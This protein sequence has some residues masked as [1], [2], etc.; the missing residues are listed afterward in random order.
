M[1]LEHGFTARTD[2]SIMNVF[3]HKEECKFLNYFPNSD[4]GRNY[5][6][7]QNVFVIFVSAYPSMFS[8]RIC[9]FLEQPKF[10]ILFIL[11][12]LYVVLLLV[13]GGFFFYGGRGDLFRISL[14]NITM[15]TF[16]LAHALFY[17]DFRR[18]LIKIRTGRT[19]SNLLRCLKQYHH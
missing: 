2:R 9:A 16:R 10:G 4:T 8:Y 6:S 17:S 19:S 14:I 3:I 13:F 12:L 15:P 5:R 18:N 7:R 1:L 11:Y